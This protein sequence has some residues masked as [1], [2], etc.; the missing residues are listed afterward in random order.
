MMIQSG[1]AGV[2]AGYGRYVLRAF[3]FVWTMFVGIQVA[4]SYRFLY[5]F[6]FGCAARCHLCC[7]SK[8]TFMT[9]GPMT[10]LCA[11]ETVNRTPPVKWER[12]HSDL[13]FY[14]FSASDKVSIC[15]CRGVGTRT[16]SVIKTNNRRWIELISIL[17][18]LALLVDLSH[19]Y[20]ERRRFYWLPITSDRR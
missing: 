20:E 5:E 16:L 7:C 15:S 13:F 19:I 18:W 3:V 9:E 4:H 10:K 6:E 11:Q 2:P 14:F 17:V 12:D 8:D 1:I